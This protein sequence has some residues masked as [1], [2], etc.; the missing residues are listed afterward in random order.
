MTWELGKAG[1]NQVQVVLFQGLYKCRV[2]ALVTKPP[3]VSCSETGSSG[4]A[5]CLIPLGIL[6]HF[7]YLPGCQFPVS[8]AYSH[9]SFAWTFLEGPQGSLV[10]S[11]KASWSWAALLMEGISLGKELCYQE[12]SRW[13]QL[14]ALGWIAF[15]SLDLET[16]VQIPPLGKFYLNVLE[17]QCHHLKYRNDCFHFLYFK[18]FCKDQKMKINEEVFSKL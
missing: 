6:G 2:P 12:S 13:L 1:R 7:L 8:E 18:E 11:R 5:L 16:T 15:K 14:A 10:L 17:P 3:T 9:P 4:S